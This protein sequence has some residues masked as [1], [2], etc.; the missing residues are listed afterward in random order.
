MVQTEPRV[1]GTD[2]VS[3]VDDLPEHVMQLFLDTFEQ[4]DFPVEATYGLKQLTRGRLLPLRQ[5]I[6]AF[7]RS[8]NMI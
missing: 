2:L 7:V 6:L 4:A 5:R 1:E 8:S 3:T